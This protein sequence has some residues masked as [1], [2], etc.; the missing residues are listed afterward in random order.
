MPVPERAIFIAIAL[1]G[2][3]LFASAAKLLCENWAMLLPQVLKPLVDFL[4]RADGAVL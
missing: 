1:A 3:L 2:L 4:A